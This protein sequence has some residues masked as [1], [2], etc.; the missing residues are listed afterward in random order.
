MPRQPN[1]DYTLPL[2]PVV[3]GTVV[4]ASWANTSLADLGQAL[5][6]SL[7]RTGQG[8]MSE[9]VQLVD[10]TA[11]APGL[12]FS[13]EA[14]SGLHR[15][16]P[17][18]IYMSVLGQNYMRWTDDNGVQVST[19]GIVWITVANTDTTDTLQVEVDANTALIGDVLTFLITDMT[20]ANN[21]L[22][23][24]RTDG[25]FT[26]TIEDFDI[27]KSGGSITH[28]ST[29]L[30]GAT[31]SPDI[32]AATRFT[33]TN[34]GSITITFNRPTGADSDLGENYCVEGSILITN[35][36]TP[37]TV[38]INNDAGAVAAANI[39]GVQNQT[40][41]AVMVLSYI[42]HRHTGDTYDEIYSWAS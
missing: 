11:G 6:D 40:P 20:W 36:A 7:S 38:T 22:T 2:P 14:N 30:T 4:E 19:D 17:G 33:M 35:T 5:T 21:T 41:N 9:P 34:N 42:I 1:G 25:N 37:N 15:P 12:G 8:D 23:S 39:L 18:D 10:G 27:F 3:G 24:V 26:V 16:A 32:T 13:S 28:L 31:P 29:E